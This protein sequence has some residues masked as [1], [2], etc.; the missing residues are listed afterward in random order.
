MRGLEEAE[1]NIGKERK[2]GKEEEQTNI[3]EIARLKTSPPTVGR[4]S[5]L[6]SHKA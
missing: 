1:N 3:C 2:R 5:R 4:G 6:Y